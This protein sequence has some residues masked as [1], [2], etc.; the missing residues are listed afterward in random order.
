MEAIVNKQLSLFL[1]SNNILSDTQSGFRARRGCVTAVLKVLND[2][3]MSL[4]KNHC[5]AAIFIDLP[6][7]FDT[8][9]HSILNKLR[10][11]GCDRVSAAW[12]QNY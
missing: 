7:T 5:C 12:F 10:S 2:I 4:D 11:T 8:V 9:D 3:T 1:E 6:K